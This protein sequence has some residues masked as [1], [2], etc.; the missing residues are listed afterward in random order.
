MYII[1]DTDLPSKEV[2][3]VA[4]GA[5]TAGAI[6]VVNSDETVSVVAATPVAES[7]G[8]PGSFL[9]GP[10]AYIA[11]TYDSA[12]QKVVVAYRDVN[13]QDRGYVKVGTVSGS[14]ITFGTAV[15][16]GEGVS[17]LWIA[18]AYDANAGKVVICYSPSVR[19]YFGTARVGTIS[20]TSI[21]LG[22]P[23]VF[24]STYSDYTSATYDETAQKTVI[25]YRDAGGANYGKAV[26]GT[27]SGTSISFGTKVFL[28]STNTQYFC[29]A[30]D[31]G[32]G[33]VVVAYYESY[34]TFRVITISGTSIS[35]GTAYVSSFR[36]YGVG[37]GDKPAGITYDASS[38]SLVFAFND[39]DTGGGSVAAGS[40]SGTTVSFGAK[41]SFLANGDAASVDISYHAAAEKVVITYE[42]RATLYGRIVTGSVSGSSITLD[43][44]ITINS[45][46][47]DYFM[48]VYD[49][50]NAKTVIFYR[51]DGSSDVGEYVVYNPAY[52]TS[53]LTASNFI[54]FSKAGYANGQGATIQIATS[55]NDKQSGLT[56]GQS[57]YVL[58]DGTLSTT[59]GSPSVFAGTA[60]SSN[61]LVVKG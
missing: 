1:G 23:T 48:P 43:T 3:A 40:A 39:L 12:N 45:T 14:T 54:G 57:Y 47:S 11:A 8:T 46:S 4:S 32:I 52:T 42:D 61:A 6:V 26:V 56:P 50:S 18:L 7:T 21:T 35:L 37:G 22:T 34:F 41:T 17:T 51:D 10:C 28:T 38:G 20:G 60:V 19:S 58:P 29:G 53:N 25:A 36:V 33:K 2:R 24:D 27:V 59:A 13:T 5:L 49:A 31:A 15:E 30:Y 44:P 9:S 16:F 55:V